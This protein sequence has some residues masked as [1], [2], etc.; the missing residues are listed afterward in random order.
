MENKRLQERL[1]DEQRE[2]AQLMHTQIQ[3]A[4]LQSTNEELQES[5]RQLQANLTNA[6]SEKQ[7]EERKVATLRS[8]MLLQKDIYTAKLDEQTTRIQVLMKDLDCLRGRLEHFEIPQQTISEGALFDSPEQDEIDQLKEHISTLELEKKRLTDLA[9]GSQ[10]QISENDN[11]KVTIESLK[12]Q[13][14]TFQ[15]DTS[16]ASNRTTDPPNRAVD[17][18]GYDLF[19]L[20]DTQPKRLPQKHLSRHSMAHYSEDYELSFLFHTLERGK[21]QQVAETCKVDKALITNP[22]SALTQFTT[23]EAVI[24]VEDDRTPGFR[25]MR[26]FVEDSDLEHFA[27][28]LDLLIKKEKPAHIYANPRFLQYKRITDTNIE[29]PLLEAHRIRRD[30]LLIG[31]EKDTKAF[32][33][34]IRLKPRKRQLD[35]ESYL[36][37]REYIGTHIDMV[38]HRADDASAQPLRLTQEDSAASGQL[39]LWNK[40]RTSV[41]ATNEQQEDESSAEQEQTRRYKRPTYERL[42]RDDGEVVMSEINSMQDPSER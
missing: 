5:E 1:Q 6:R 12:S 31:L 15:N 30:T 18:L 37:S 35:G 40:Q 33:K 4:A 19:A 34:F 10:V 41:E 29:R 26:I 20:L 23:L 21:Y 22:T 7:A 13:L 16:A 39:V 24:I 27:K 17:Q 2:T 3:F 36:V 28:Q 32:L 8:D 25:S 9:S 38:D 11:L 14:S 42:Q